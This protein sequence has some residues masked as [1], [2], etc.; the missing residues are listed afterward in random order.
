[1]N[2]AL[3]SKVALVVI[4]VSIMWLAG[5]GVILAEQVTG[6]V[7][8]SARATESSEGCDWMI[9]QVAVGG[10]EYPVYR[11]SPLPPPDPGTRAGDLVGLLIA[12][13]LRLE[14][15]PASLQ[16]ARVF[17][18]ADKGFNPYGRYCISDEEIVVLERA[19]LEVI[20]DPICLWYPPRAILI[21]ASLLWK[22][23]GLFYHVLTHELG[24]WSGL[25][26]EREAEQFACNIAWHQMC[27]FLQMPSWSSLTTKPT[28]A[29]AT[30]VPSRRGD[31]SV[32]AKDPQRACASGVFS[33]T[34]L[35]RRLPSALP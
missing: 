15:L 5:R 8:V 26:Y 32:F 23:P 28:Q 33:F 11:C 7:R 4:A 17:L 30:S 31:W 20:E 27:V 21:R 19:G 1:M 10:A 34:S 18:V 9:Y 14:S 6:N 35:D 12:S 3:R 2:S 25:A 22:D 24:H 29:P 13:G 16:D